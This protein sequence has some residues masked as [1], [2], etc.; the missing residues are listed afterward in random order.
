VSAGSR[1]PPPA[2]G[3]RVEREEAQAALSA[4]YELGEGMEPEII[5][6]FLDRVEHAIDARVDAR[7]ARAGR[8]SRLPVER[9]SRGFVGR[10]AASL[11]FGIPLTGLVIPISEVS[12][13]VGGLTALGIWASIITLNVYYTEVEKEER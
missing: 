7:M 1:Q 2:P 10:I 3:P 9:R 11:G 12:P 4:R 5:D 6:A 8:G 13:F